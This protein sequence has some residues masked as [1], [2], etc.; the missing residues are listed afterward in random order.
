MKKIDFLIREN[1]KQKVYLTENTLDV[2]DILRNDYEYIYDSIIEE[3]FLL[4]SNEC[5]LF[6]E[7]VFDDK[8]VGFC[9]YD[10]SREFITAALNNIYVLPEYRG[11]G[12]FKK[13]LEKTLTE[14]NKPSIIEPTHLVVD[15]LIKYGYAK[16]IN[17]EIVAS[18]LEFI[19]PGNHVLS[20]GE[21]D[22]S[23]E[24]STHFY[25]LNISASIH[26]LDL[27]NSKIAYSS[28][29]NYDIIHYDAFEKRKDLDDKYIRGIKEF[30]EENEVEIMKIVL[31]LEEKL[32]VIS[33][34]LEE[35]IG[36]GD[37]LS[38]YIESLID[39]AHI[40]YS[41]ALKIKEQ[42]KEEYEAGMILNESLLIRLAYLF[43]EN[44]QT[45]KSHSE[46][47]PYCDMPIDNH[48]K[49]C[50]FCGINLKYNPAAVEKSLINAMEFGES[51]CEEDI[52]YVAYKFLRMIESKIDLDYA[53]INT[54][55]SYN[56]DWLDLETFLL[57]NDYFNGKG[58]TKK[59]FDFLNN[60]PLHYYEKYEM[61]LIDY[62]DFEKYFYENKNLNG[63]EIC[64]S[65]LEQFKDDE[66]ISE[67]IRQINFNK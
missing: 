26:F 39:D 58:I 14:H 35:V 59:G 21:Y 61:T 37:E 7:L 53:I 9:S 43:N 66:E 31:E 36:R 29:L 55:K 33:Y 56:I 40:T 60:H 15:L 25:D 57:K 28:P 2:T 22:T 30:F 19:I 41:D 65:Y 51:D 5:S 13:E 1:N 45:I 16:K 6:K 42:I 27:E 8:V 17:D 50:H 64:I 48:D 11:N 10:F 67:L 3:N 62:T 12:L 38:P 4:K 18:C 52:K 63:N 23:E 20:N 34:T 44:S 47:C 54:E 24:L 49:Y 32:P 46:T